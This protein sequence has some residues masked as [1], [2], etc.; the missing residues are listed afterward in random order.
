MTETKT[1]TQP[2]KTTLNK[3]VETFAPGTIVCKK[4]GD[5]ISTDLTGTV[6]CQAKQSNCPLVAQYSAKDET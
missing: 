4:C 3:I 1:T 6:I 2:K 5:K